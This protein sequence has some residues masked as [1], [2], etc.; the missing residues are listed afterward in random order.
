M[1][2]WSLA[3]VAVAAAASGLG[4]VVVSRQGGSYNSFLRQVGFCKAQSFDTVSRNTSS[5]PSVFESG[6]VAFGVGLSHA[7]FNR[8]VVSC[9]RCIEVLTVDRF[10][11]FNAELTG[12][13]YEEE[14]VGGN[15]TVMV[16]DECTDPICGSGFLDFDVY[17]TR[18]PVAR[19]NPTNLTWRYA[20]CPVADGDR[21]GFLFC[22]GYG[23]CQ[24]H[25]KEGRMVAE[26]FQEAVDDDWVRVYPR[27]SRIPITSLSVQGQAL[28]DNQSW[29]W[30]GPVGD[31]PVWLVEWQNAD[32]TRQSWVMDWSAY[33]DETTTPG[34]RG[35]FVAHT[36]LQ[37]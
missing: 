19:G 21:I 14:Q 29:L 25:D 26:V 36:D 22:L 5:G 6:R 16:M 17:S 28:S 24:A 31:D 8:S 23:S 10:Y 30:E 18:Q 4:D 7:Q 11:A 9:G 33:F 35:G 3:L 2:W 12:W 13:D 37:N 34:Y 15:F 32:G 27:N 20:P 1:R